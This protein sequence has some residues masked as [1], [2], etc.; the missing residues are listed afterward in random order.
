MTL[1]LNAQL[2][3]PAYPRSATYDP[4]W[5][6]TRCRSRIRDFLLAFPANGLYPATS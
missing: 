5:H 6:R 4:Q 3:L 1:D 2:T